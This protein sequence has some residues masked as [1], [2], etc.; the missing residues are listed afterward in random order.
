M[1]THTLAVAGTVSGLANNQ[2]ANTVAENL[3]KMVPSGTAPTSASTGFAS[4]SGL[5]WHDTTTNQVKIR[6]QADTA[7]IVIGSLDETNKLFAAAATGIAAVQGTHKNLK[8]DSRTGSVVVTADEL[9]LETAGNTY[10]VVRGASLTINPAV[11]GANGLDTGSFAPTT[12]YAVWVIYNGTTVAGLLSTSGT[13]PTLPSGYSYKARVG[14]VRSNATP[15]LYPIL[16]FGRRAQ[17][18]VDGAVLTV[19]R[20]I[21]GAVGSYSDTTPVYAAQAIATFVPPTAGEIIAFMAANSGTNAHGA[22][23]PNGN[24]SGAKSAIPPP[25]SKTASDATGTP[26]ALILESATI[27]V[28][29]NTSA[30]LY[31][32][33]WVDNL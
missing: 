32:A 3:A 12:W 19:P 23:A 22:V 25:F 1:T 16:Q 27:H 17:Y 30:S 24:Y 8:L 11:S 18:V 33:G 13:A 26:F 10:A 14:W 21:C 7:W 6:D 20:K 28:V 31:C 4:L 2:Q 15:A 29:T 5:W 9:V